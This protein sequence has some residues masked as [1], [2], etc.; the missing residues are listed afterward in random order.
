MGCLDQYASP[1]QCIPSMIQPDTITETIL[2]IEMQL[3]LNWGITGFLDLSIIRYSKGHWRTKRFGNWICFCPQM[4]GR[5]APTLLGPLE[6]SNPNQC[7]CLPPPHLRTERLCNSECHTPSSEPFR[8]NSTQ[9][10]L[11]HAGF[12]LTYLTHFLSTCVLITS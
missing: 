5:E 1:S 10:S 11:W 9:A 8:T 7:R 2:W 4:R 3:L 6:R 12:Y